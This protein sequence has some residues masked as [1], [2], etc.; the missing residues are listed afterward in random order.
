MS[1]A[2]NEIT[3][4]K[5]QTR[6]ISDAYR[7]NFDKIFRANKPEESNCNNCS[8]CGCTAKG[9]QTLGANKN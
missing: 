7:E 2:T 9:E 6:T 8:N 4:D 3:G 1:T 5:I